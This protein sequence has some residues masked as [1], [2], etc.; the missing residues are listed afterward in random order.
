MHFISCQLIVNYD[1]CETY[2][3]ES[4]ALKYLVFIS[5]SFSLL[6]AMFLSTVNFYHMWSGNISLDLVNSNWSLVSC[7]ATISQWCFWQLYQRVPTIPQFILLK[8]FAHASIKALSKLYFFFFSHIYPF[9]SLEYQ[10]LGVFKSSLFLRFQHL[11]ER[12][13]STHVSFKNI[14]VE[15]INIMTI[16]IFSLSISLYLPNFSNSQ[17][18]TLFH[19]FLPAYQQFVTF[20]TYRLVILSFI[21]GY[22]YDCSILFCFRC[23]IL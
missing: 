20:V 5:V 19:F 12:S 18:T 3:G 2:S 7:L 13:T 11:T 9:L 6:F 23:I 17:S 4:L 14:I 1:G 8:H 21:V 22:S 10:L 15:G 16:T